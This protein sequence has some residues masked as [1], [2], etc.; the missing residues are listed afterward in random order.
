MIAPKDMTWET[1]RIF[2]RFDEYGIESTVEMAVDKYENGATAKEIFEWLVEDA[3]NMVDHYYD[4]GKLDD[5]VHPQEARYDDG[6]DYEFDW[7][8]VS[9]SDIATI[10]YNYVV[11]ELDAPDDMPYRD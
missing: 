7:R 3:E 1:R 8:S 6:F 2:S 9:Y 5:I 4:R 11:D 10:I